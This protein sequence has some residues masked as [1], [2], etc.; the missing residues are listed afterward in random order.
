MCPACFAQPG[1]AYP[2]HLCALLLHLD[3]SGLSYLRPDRFAIISYHSVN[4]PSSHLAVDEREALYLFCQTLRALYPLSV[5]KRRPDNLGCLVSQGDGYDTRCL[6]LEQLCRPL[7]TVVFLV[8]KTDHCRSAQHEL[9]PKITVTLL[10]DASLTEKLR[11][12]EQPQ[13]SRCSDRADTGNVRQPMADTV[14][15]MLGDDLLLDIGDPL[16][17][18]PQM[19]NNILKQLPSVLRHHLDRAPESRNRARPVMRRATY[20]H[21]DQ[22]RRERFEKPE[23][24]R[25]P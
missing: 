2:D 20:L 24:F 16:L 19:R 11:H 3:P 1:A 4:S 21:T 25:P 6:L 5:V 23:N 13:R 14:S 22:T 17:K 9:V 10:A 18:S 7:P 15:P 12:P 8:C